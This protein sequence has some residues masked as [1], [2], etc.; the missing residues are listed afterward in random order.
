MKQIPMVW[1]LFVTVLCMTLWGAC[2]TRTEGCLELNANNF[3]LDAERPCKDCCTYPSINLLLTQKWNDDNFSNEDTLY[4]IHAQ[5][6]KIQDL[7]Y[8]LSSWS[9]NNSDGDIFTVDSISGT[10]NQS[11]LMFT[12]DILTTDTRKFNYKLGTIRVAPLADSLFFTFG[13]VEDFSCLDPGEASTPSNLKAQS[14]LWNPNTAMLATL[15]LVLQ[16]DL[17]I[18]TYDTV[19]L[20]TK[21]DIYL[22]YAFQFRNGFNEQFNLTI[23]YAQWFQDVDIG[24]LTSFENSIVAHFEGSIS[25]TP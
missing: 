4:D 10:C 9:W 12:P 5:P 16:R 21:K 19:F 17:E 18:A 20:T 8:F 2:N 13:L 15:R 25:P 11:T 3:D 22:P 24:D 14:S 7:K 1:V 23:N 6:Y